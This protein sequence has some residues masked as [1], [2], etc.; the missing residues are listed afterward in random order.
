VVS[1]P[2]K[3]R[4][5]KNRSE[6]LLAIFKKRKEVSRQEI[7]NVVKMSGP[8]ISYWLR[9]LVEEEKIKPTTGSSK[10]PNVKYTLKKK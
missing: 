4:E 10:N 2:L 9:K 6:E 3:K 5:R 7:Q 1:D 8:T